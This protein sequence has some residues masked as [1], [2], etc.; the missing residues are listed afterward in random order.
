[1]HSTDARGYALGL[2]ANPDILGER[3]EPPSLMFKDYCGKSCVGVRA[4]H[5]RKPRARYAFG[6]HTVGQGLEVRSG[7]HS[8]RG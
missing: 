1:M 7:A 6:R 8:A 2:G 3:P 5:A 4:E